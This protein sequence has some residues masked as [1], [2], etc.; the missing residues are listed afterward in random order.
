MRIASFCFAAACVSGCAPMTP[1][2]YSGMTPAAHPIAWDGYPKHAGE[3]HVEGSAS[4][5]MVVE[6]WFPQVHDTALNVAATQIEGTASITPIRGLDVGIRASYAAYRWTE[7]TAVGTMPLPSHPSLVGVGPEIHGALFLDRHKH[8]ALGIAANVMHYEVP[9]AAYKLEGQNYVLM[10]EGSDSD[11]TFSGGIYPSYSFGR[12]GEYGT[13]FSMLG[14]HT[15][16]KNDG[17]AL[18]ASNGSTIEEDGFVPMVGTGYAIHTQYFH[19]SIMGYLP[20][21][22]PMV[23]GPGV[24]FGLGVDLPLWHPRARMD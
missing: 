24:M 12:D 15:A 18:T 8:V 6:N 11:W 20:L 1:Y 10:N 19:A 21:S 13:I 17:F 22:S 14:V 9:W 23:W 5:T 7:P 16:F 4:H 3:V 2:R